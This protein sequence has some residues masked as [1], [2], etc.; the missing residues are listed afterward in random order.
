VAINRTLLEELKLRGTGP[1][2][3]TRKTEDGKS[4]S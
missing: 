2:D 1:E 4:V 3:D